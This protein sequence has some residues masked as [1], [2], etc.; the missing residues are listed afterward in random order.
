MAFAH[1]RRSCGIAAVIAIGLGTEALPARAQD[2]APS[3]ALQS[4]GQAPAQA[5]ASAES[6]AAAKGVQCPSGFEALF[7]AAAKILRCRREVVTWVVTSCHEKGFGAYAA[8]RGADSCGPTEIPG[9]GVPPGS[10]GSRAVAC[11]SPGYVVVVDRTGPRDR[12]EHVEHLFALP[13]VAR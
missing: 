13:R 7:D 10:T 9:V 12:C 8:K 3:T 6:A 5:P 2:P 4:V 11:A 1:C